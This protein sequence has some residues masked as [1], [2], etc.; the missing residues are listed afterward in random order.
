[1]NYKADKNGFQADIHYNGQ[2]QNIP[3]KKVTPTTK[4]QEELPPPQ[5][6]SQP[7]NQQAHVPNSN[8]HL[9]DNDGHVTGNKKPADSQKNYHR[10]DPRNI[11]GH[12]RVDEVV[13]SR[14]N[15]KSI[16]ENVP[17]VPE[18]ENAEHHNGRSPPRTPSEETQNKKSIKLASPSLAVD[19][20]EKPDDVSDVVNQPGPPY[21]PHSTDQSNNEPRII[22]VHS[23]DD[24]GPQNSYNEPQTAQFVDVQTTQSIN[25]QNPK[26]NRRTT[27][28]DNRHT[29]II[30]ESTATIQIDQRASQYPTE[31]YH[32]NQLQGQ[33]YSPNKSILSVQRGTVAA[34]V[35]QTN[36]SPNEIVLSSFLT[37]PKL[38]FVANQ[39][40]KPD[41]KK[42]Q[43]VANRQHQP[44]LNYDH[45]T[46]TVR[47]YKSP[48][49]ESSSNVQIKTKNI[50][51]KPPN[52]IA[53]LSIGS[54]SGDNSPRYNAHFQNSPTTLAPVSETTVLHQQRIDIARTQS[55]IEPQSYQNEPVHNR[56][57]TF[58]HDYSVTPQ[59]PLNI[60]P[61]PAFT[62]STPAS[63]QYGRRVHAINRKA[64]PII[65]QQVQQIAPRH[66]RQADILSKQD[67]TIILKRGGMETA[68]SDPSLEEHSKNIGR[69][70]LKREERA[71]T[72]PKFATPPTNIIPRKQNSKNY[73]IHI[74]S[75]LPPRYRTQRTYND[76]K[77][78][79]QQRVI[80]KSDSNNAFVSFAGKLSVKE[81]TTSLPSTL[82]STQKTEPEEQ[83]TQ[84]PIAK[85]Y[86]LK[87]TI[88][89][90]KVQN[91]P[92]ATPITHV[93]QNLP[94][95]SRVNLRV[96]ALREAA[97][98]NPKFLRSSQNIAPDKGSNS[99]PKIT[100]LAYASSN[101]AEM[102]HSDSTSHPI[103]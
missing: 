38:I 18:P 77:I 22:E 48:V 36:I 1:M 85:S 41:E 87:P 9:S 6:Y 103:N 25:V 101:M 94:Q 31:V 64:A 12:Q 27:M 58:Q 88:I 33:T 37:P 62:T 81:T 99:S 4:Q 29:Q 5:T 21:L 45:P 16:Q 7:T 82:S 49:T 83:F 63:L 13:E 93:P 66:P 61:G 39:S 2:G 15:S 56:Q 57:V 11:E 90:D 10:T 23:N 68:P 97:G 43:R 46:T 24:A 32:Q 73:V 75:T 34:G 50:D 65:S 14:Q 30:P 69:S 8:N 26:I 96:P 28:Q 72:I 20:N 92:A 76:Q 53:Q 40:I 95:P 44:S 74:S 84:I 42:K 89:H 55:S 80:T 98:T 86:S 3:Q 79:P 54:L 52:S 78:S 71:N 67:D 17:E 47:A 51:H 91:P 60:S 100:P 19:K 70:P 35:V 102:Y 59:K